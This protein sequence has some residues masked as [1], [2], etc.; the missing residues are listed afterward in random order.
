MNTI[1][2]DPQTQTPGESTLNRPKS[3]TAKFKVCDPELKLY[4]IELEKENLKLHKQIAKLQA[5]NVTY[6]NEI[7]ALKKAPP[8][9]IV[10]VTNF[11]K[12]DN[13]SKK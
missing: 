4:V 8:Q 2:P 3:L 6:Q 12:H 10:K 9:M 11:A 1:S 7:T 13:K 5:Q